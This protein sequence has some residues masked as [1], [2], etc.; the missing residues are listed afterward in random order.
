MSYINYVT[1]DLND[2]KDNC[3]VVYLDY[4]KDIGCVESQL[5]L[6]TKTKV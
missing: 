4:N 5:K 1:I 3:L 2:A 6:R